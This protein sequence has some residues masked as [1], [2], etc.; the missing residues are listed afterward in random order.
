VYF[1]DNDKSSKM[2]REIC[3]L[4]EKEV[5]GGNCV[6]SDTLNREVDNNYLEIFFMVNLENLGLVG[7]V[8]YLVLVH[9]LLG[10]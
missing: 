9:G 5:S 7:M 10:F 3:L 4:F 8:R 6:R 1:V 2:I